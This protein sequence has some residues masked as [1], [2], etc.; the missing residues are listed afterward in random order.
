MAQNNRTIR[1][2]ESDYLKYKIKTDFISDKS[3]VYCNDFFE[4]NSQLPDEFADLIIID[5][6]YNLN[7]KYS[8]SSFYKKS[9]NEYYN[10]TLSILTECLKKLKSTGTLYICGDWK[11]SFIQMSCVNQLELSGE[12]FCINRITWARDKGRA[13][14]NN[15]KNNIEDII[16]IVKS[17]NYTF[18]IK[19]VMVKKTVLAPYRDSSGN[20]KDWIDG[21]LGRYRMTAPS[22][23]WNDITVPFWSMKENTDHPTQKPEKLYAKLILASSNSND[24]VYEPFCG[25]GTACVTAKKLGRKYIGVEKEKE[26]CLLAYK[27]LDFA[28]TD[29][30]I[31]G[32]ENHIFTNKK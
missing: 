12:C 26:Y 30:S 32:Y 22:N 21:S 20:N 15:W 29:P 13:K 7:K 31:Q 4:F 1:L 17:D 8:E 11:T 6:P 14:R 24:I 3:D 23:I 16:M 10:Y 9:Y 18:N 2:T 27:R 5:P 25:T 28:E 19:D